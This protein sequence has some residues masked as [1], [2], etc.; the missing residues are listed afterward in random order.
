MACQVKGTSRIEN[1]SLE[2][3]IG[4]LIESMIRLGIS[5]KRAGRRT[6][7]VNGNNF[8]PTKVVVN[9]PEDRNVL[10]TR[11]MAAV[12]TGK[13]FSYRSKT[14]LQLEPLVAVLN[15]MGVDVEEKKY[16][17]AFSGK[18]IKRLKPVDI[19][20]DHYPAFCSDWHP[21]IAPI[22]AKIPGTSTITDNIFE[23]RFGY[24]D[25]LKK[26][27]PS[28]SYR[29][30][31]RTLIVVGTRPNTDP[32][33]KRECVLRSLD[34]RCGAMNVIASLAEDADTEVTNTDQ[35]FRGY[36]NIIDDMNAVAPGRVRY[37]FDI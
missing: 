32:K 36:E 22:L 5:V 23:D 35:I 14:P 13:G 17:I 28:L 2:P 3:E 25:E 6:I 37:R 24:I 18:A 8:R 7:T 1:A 29:I 31:K 16:S 19:I 4:T 26:I 20:A 34:L 15:E 12:A 11:I 27:I 9:I 30:E 10:V 21:L 33:K